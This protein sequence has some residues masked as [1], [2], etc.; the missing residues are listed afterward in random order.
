MD[1]VQKVERYNI[2]K[3]HF[4]KLHEKIQNKYNEMQKKIEKS[5]SIDMLMCIG[6]NFIYKEPK[7]HL[8]TSDVRNGYQD[9]ERNIES[10][11]KL[12]TETMKIE[13]SKEINVSYEEINF[14]EVV[15]T[16]AN[17][18]IGNDKIESENEDNLSDNIFLSDMSNFS[19]TSLESLQDIGR[20]T[21]E[22]S[23]PPTPT[24]KSIRQKI[25][26]RMTAVK[27]KRNAYR[28][29]KKEVREKVE[30]LILTNSPNDHYDKFLKRTKFA[31]TTIALIE[32]SGFEND[33]EKFRF[34]ICRLRLGLEKR[35]SKVIKT[36][37][38]VVKWQ[39]V[40]HISMYEETLLEISLWDRDV[41]MGKC[42][43]DLS[44]LKHEKTHKMRINLEGD[45]RN[46]KLF[47]LITISGT[48]L[49]NTILDLDDYQNIRNKLSMERKKFAWYRTLKDFSDVGWLSVIVF[50]AKGLP[51]TDCSCIL[52]LNNEALYT[53]TVHKTNEPNWM[54]IFT[55]TVTDITSV[56]EVIVFDEK[57]SEDVGKISI[58]LLKISTN[59]KKWYALKG[60]NLKEK[61]KGNNPRILLEMGITWNLIKASVRVINPKEADLL[62]TEDKLDRHIFA[63]N[64][65]RAK[66]IYSWTMSTFQI[67]KTMFEWESRKSNIIALIAWLFFCWIFKIWMLPLLLL[68]PFAWYKPSKNPVLMIRR[69]FEQIPIEGEEIPKQEKEEKNLTLRQKIN[70]LQDMVH[71][72]Q[73]VIGKFASLGESVKN[74]FNFSVPFVSCLAI[75]LIL[76][77]TLVMYLI[78]LKY[79][80][81]I[82]GIHKFTR[83]ILKPNR[84]PNN[85]ILDLLS[86]VPDDETLIDWEQYSLETLSD[87]DEHL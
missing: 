28:E 63:R 81:M 52:K 25:G 38:S 8:S 16:E 69:R 80:L 18:D 66:A 55:F 9:N 64:I 31:T 71:T 76:F 65:S 23:L 60:I 75:F 6:D 46:I 17:N 42:V 22:S 85:E 36:N 2:A 82:W 33:D 54:K 56:L 30:K 84:I 4:P 13:S 29:K 70:S 41:F 61:A 34:L 49:N 27:E 51:T 32:A 20:E 3:S 73:N 53:H 79:I 12:R 77:I 37:K 86:R 11:N 44:L 43:V 72:V 47:F 78:P 39:D 48:V 59:D 83:K 26:L 7:R 35:K 10:E 87:E 5:K 15:V 19:K 21:D 45:G 67:F 62:E 58:P 74:L 40:I 50:G 14:K 1:D 24:T 68:I 57:R